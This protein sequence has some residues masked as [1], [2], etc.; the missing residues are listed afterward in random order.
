MFF[1][2]FAIITLNVFAYSFAGKSYSGIND[3]LILVSII[4]AVIIAVLIGIALCYIV[5]EKCNKRRE[6]YVSA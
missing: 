3:E 1:L 5:R 6:Y 2:H 4:M